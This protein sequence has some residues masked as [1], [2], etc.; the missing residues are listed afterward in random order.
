MG[1]L[2]HQP[3]AALNCFVE[4]H[5]WPVRFLG[6]TAGSIRYELALSSS[7]TLFNSAP[8]AAQAIQ[9]YQLPAAARVVAPNAAPGA[10]G[11]LPYE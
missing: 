5:G 2:I 4:L 11:T 8:A 3:P 6:Q 1:P 10:S 9:D 7:P